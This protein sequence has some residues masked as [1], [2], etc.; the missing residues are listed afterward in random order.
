VHLKDEARVTQA[1]IV[2]HERLE[3]ALRWIAEKQKQRDTER[4]AN[5]KITLRAK[6]RIRESAAESAF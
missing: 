6:R 3:A 1:S 4:L 5:P 2:E